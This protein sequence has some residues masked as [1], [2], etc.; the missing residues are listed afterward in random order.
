MVCVF[1]CACVCVCAQISA[2]DYIC[3]IDN[4]SA[5]MSLICKI[6]VTCT[7]NIL[8]NILDGYGKYNCFFFFFLLNIANSY[9]IY[10]LFVTY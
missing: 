9:S 10:S 3:T 5:Y 4:T 8:Q 6:G 2:S 1:A 7:A